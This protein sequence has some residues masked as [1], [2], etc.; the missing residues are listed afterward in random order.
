[1]GKKKQKLSMP[2]WVFWSLWILGVL[3]SLFVIF[4]ASF[5]VWVSTWQTYRN[6]EFGLSFRYPRDWYIGGTDITMKQF[7]E[8]N[9][10]FFWIDSAPPEIVNGYTDLN[11]SPGNVLVEL[12]KKPSNHIEDLISQGKL[13]DIEYTPI[14]YGQKLGYTRYTDLVSGNSNSVPKRVLIDTE[15][16]VGDISLDY[17]ESWRELLSEAIGSEIIKSFKF[18]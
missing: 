16:Y 13:Y 7:D 1:M 5:Q 18:D 3:A 11:T 12:S 17:R 14:K 10:V 15:K 9:V 2:V 8:R 4:Y 6:D